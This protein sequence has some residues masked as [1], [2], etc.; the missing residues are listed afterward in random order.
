MS[1]RRRSQLCSIDPASG[2]VITCKYLPICHDDKQTTR[3][4]FKTPRSNSFPR[5]HSYLYFRKLIAAFLFRFLSVRHPFS[6]KL[7]GN[8]HGIIK[9]IMCSGNRIIFRWFCHI[10]SGKIYEKL[11]EGVKIVYSSVGR[12]RV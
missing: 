9:S 11:M 1:A 6:G 8:K 3:A 4:R 2:S 7:R 5:A 12:I 10:N